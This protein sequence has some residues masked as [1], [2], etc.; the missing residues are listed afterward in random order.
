MLK[1]EDLALKSMATYFHVN[2]EIQGADGMQTLYLMNPSYVPYSDTSSLPNNALLLN[3][4]SLAHAPPPSNDHHHP[5]VGIPLPAP[6]TNTDQT[7]NSED[8]NRSSSL[9]A[10]VPGIHYDL[11]SSNIDQNSSQSH[12]HMVSLAAAASNSNQLGLLRPLASS[13][14]CRQQGLSLSLSPQQAAVGYNRLINIEG[15]HPE[16]GGQ[17]TVSTSGD[18]MRFSESSPSSVS[19]VS[20]GISSIQSA[21]LGSKYLRAAQELL[22]EVVKVGNVIKTD[23]IEEGKENMKF[24]RESNLAATGEESNGGESSTKPAA[25]LTTAQR[26]ELHIK[27]AKLVSMLDEVR[28]SNLSASLLP[29]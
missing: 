23:S 11:W 24:S 17:V 1:G 7:N 21:I 27:K 16:G 9:Q 13:S 14:S 26:Q 20:N 29:S 10:I 4:V 8:I 22:D 19:A 18:F 12:P 25:E 28:I 5:L 3:S 2:S 15:D 6:S